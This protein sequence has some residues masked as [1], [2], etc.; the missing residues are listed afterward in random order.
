MAFR[1]LIKST[2]SLK[3]L[4][5]SSGTTDNETMQQLL[6]ATLATL[7]QLVAELLAQ[8]PTLKCKRVWS[9]EYG[10]CTVRMKYF[11]GFKNIHVGVDNKL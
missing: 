3:E 8:H 4:L 10:A 2:R 1:D 11:E 7:G 9:R 5:G 6:L